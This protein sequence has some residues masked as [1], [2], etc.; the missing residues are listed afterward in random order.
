MLRFF[1]LEVFGLISGCRWPFQAHSMCG[2]HCIAV[3]VA[4]TVTTGQTCFRG[5]EFKSLVAR[6]TRTWLGVREAKRER[7][8]VLA[9]RM[10]R[11]CAYAEENY[12]STVVHL[13]ISWHHIY[14][15]LYM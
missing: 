10:Q 6:G 15:P 14:L 1:V 12:P 5:Q 3:A 11:V 8:V 4:V 7:F 9:K 2:G 13:C